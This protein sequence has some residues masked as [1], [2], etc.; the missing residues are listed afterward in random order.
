MNEAVVVTDGE[1]R[2]ALAVVRSLGNAGYHPVV[3]SARRHSLAGASR[4]ARSESRVPDP[5]GSPEAFTEA[6][7]RLVHTVDARLVLPVSEAALLALVPERERLRPA[8]IPFPDAA[9]VRRI[10]D[11]GTVLEVAQGLG[12]SIPRQVRLEVPPA[13]TTVHPGELAYPVVVKP[14]RSVID[15]DGGRRKASVRYARDP[16]ELALVLA[17]V[18]PA[19]YPVLLQER[20]VGPGVGVFVLL[21]EGRLVAACAHRRLRE[22]PPSGGVSVLRETIA[23]DPALL[24]RSVTLLRRLEWQGVAMVEY[25][26]DVAG[27]PYLMEINGRF[28]GSLQLAIDAGVDFPNLLVRLA[29]GEA[30]RPCLEYRIGVRSWW[31]LGDLDHLLLRLRRSDDALALPPD[32]PG[33]ARVVAEF[34]RTAVSRDQNEVFRWEDPRP[35]VR[36]ALAWFR[37]E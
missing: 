16:A 1:Q 26:L 9:R 25:K 17:A 4:H 29:L 34:L 12:I 28:W 10:C 15:S 14:V 11:K 37:R 31:A 20:I 18:D 24:D 19:A 8:I 3:C 23:L 30:V 36:E 7:E 32:E 35:A 22:K 13:P 27:R 5:L 21:W 33:R 6:V 2:A